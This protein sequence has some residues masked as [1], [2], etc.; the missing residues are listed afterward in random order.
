MES[1][2]DGAENLLESK[3]FKTSRKLPYLPNLH[4]TP[5]G[6]LIKIGTFPYKNDFYKDKYKSTQRFEG[7]I[8][9]QIS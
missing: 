3:P 1:L 7:L 8:L 6:H 5:R 2:S 9:K 4:T